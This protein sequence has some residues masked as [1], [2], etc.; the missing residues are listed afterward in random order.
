MIGLF[1]GG[2]KINPQSSSEKERPGVR[3][4]D[5]YNPEA[6]PTIANPQSSSENERPGVRLIDIYNPEANPTIANPQSAGNPQYQISS[7]DEADRQ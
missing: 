1:I 5:I 6:N 3:L 4:I 2:S 7:L